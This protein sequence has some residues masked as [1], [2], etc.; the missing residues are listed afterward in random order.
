[1]DQ[2]FG[3]LDPDSPIL[4][5]V[6]G[7]CETPT[8]HIAWDIWPC[9]AVAFV[10]TTP[11]MCFHL[12]SH[13]YCD[14]LEPASTFALQAL[15]TAMMQEKTATTKKATTTLALCYMETALW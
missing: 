1:M 10:A 7:R 9:L 15:P 5:I 6:R 4:L 12:T 2:C 3:Y 8:C 11:T 13:R 14:D